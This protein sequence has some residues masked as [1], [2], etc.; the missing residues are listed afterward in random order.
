MIQ[1]PKM[2]IIEN[3]PDDVLNAELANQMVKR[4]DKLLDNNIEMALRLKQAREFMA[5][6]A[7][8]LRELWLNWMDETEKT[9]HQM[10]IFRMSF[11]RES[12]S[13]VA[14]AKDIK[15]FFNAP[16]YIEA[17]NRL[18]EMVGLIDRFKE[19]KS[20]GTL[21]AFAD[22]ILKVSCK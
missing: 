1:N 12:K 7:S 21:D 22:F 11:E 15:E 20:E 3:K 18:K 2:D 14:S 6:L 5:W 10:N 9:S 8:H 4:T 19:L 13:I 17:H 16:D